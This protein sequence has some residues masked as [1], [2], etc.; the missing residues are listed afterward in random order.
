MVKQ[1]A[2]EA[3]LFTTFMPKP[4]TGAGAPRPLQQAWP[5]R[6]RRPTCSRRRGR[7]G[8]GLVEDGLRLRARAAQAR[9][10]AGRHLHADG[11]LLQAPDPAARRR[12]GVV[13]PGLGGLRR[14][15][16]LVHGSPAPEP[17]G[18]REPGG[19]L[20]GE[21]LPGLGLPAGGRSRWHRRR[22]R[23]R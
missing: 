15:Q 16:P 9:P 13:G 23:S 3:G 10:C 8:P 11:Q 12:H 18:G 19:R 17:A 14:Q 22:A 2:K 20:G 21:R 5:T 4:Y 6:N 7:P 1:V